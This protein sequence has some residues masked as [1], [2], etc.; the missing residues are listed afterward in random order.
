M[1][2]LR[3]KIGKPWG[4]SPPTV[5]RILAYNGRAKM[6]SR[7]Y[8]DFFRINANAVLL[9]VK[10]VFGTKD[11]NNGSNFVRLLIARRLFTFYAARTISSTTIIIAR[12]TFP[13]SYFSYGFFNTASPHAPDRSRVFRSPAGEVKPFFIRPTLTRRVVPPP[14]LTA[15]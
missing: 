14:S 12:K 11:L 13:R 10:R 6:G 4:K 2:I 5:K 7:N 1:S 9:K 8:N 15:V 3:G